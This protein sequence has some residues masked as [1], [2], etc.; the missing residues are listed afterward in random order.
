[1]SNISQRVREYSFAC[2][3]NWIKVQGISIITLHV[4]ELLTDDNKNN[5]MKLEIL[6]LLLNN[7]NLIETEN[8]EKFIERLCKSLLKYLIN[9]NMLI[10]NNTEKLIKKLY[11]TI[12]EGSY[13]EEINNSNIFDMNEKE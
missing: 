1:M 2:I 11:K 4:P 8:D 5:T 6:N 9:N 3:Q 13:I 10:R 7:Y 12:K